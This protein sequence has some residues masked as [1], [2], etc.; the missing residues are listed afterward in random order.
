MIRSRYKDK[1]S[2]IKSLSTLPVVANNVLQLTHNP[3][4]SALQVGEAISQDP[5]LAS[6]VLSVANSP[7]YGFPRKITT[8]HSSIVVLGFANIRN[9]VLTASIVDVLP[10]KGNNGS[11]NREEFWKHSLACGVASKLIAKR[12]GIKNAEEAFLWGLLHDLGKIVLDGYFTKEFALAVH[13]AKAKETLLKD[14]EEKIFGADHA[15]VGAMVADKWNLPP[16]LIKGIRHH[17]SPLSANESM[18]VAAIVH[19]ADILCRAI[20]LGNGG[21]RKIPGINE[22]SWKLLNMG[23]ETLQDLFSEIEQGVL[24]AI[25]FLSFVN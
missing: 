2:K 8:I 13:Q 9:L 7:F 17:H 15:E 19:I 4:S 14:A 18:R 20:G 24:S 21:D 5:A 16:A 10:S 6:K 3:K 23:K 1:L 11:F 22:D 25:S 12:I